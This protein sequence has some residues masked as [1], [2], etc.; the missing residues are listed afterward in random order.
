MHVR[1]DYRGGTNFLY[2]LG[3]KPDE[4]VLILTDAY[5]DVVPVNI[6]KEIFSARCKNVEIA[7]LPVD[8][9]PEF[10]VAIQRK[11]IDFDVVIITASQSWYH[12]PTRKRAKYEMKKRIVECYGLTIDL[13]K[14][15][16][17]CADPASMFDNAQKMIPL[18]KPGKIITIE[19][20]IGTVFSAKI[21]GVYI[22]TGDYREKGSGGNLPAGE[23]SFGLVEETANGTVVFDVSMDIL[24][25][26]QKRPL[27][28]EIRDGKVTDCSGELSQNF[29][30]L[31]KN[32]PRLKNIAE[33][34]IGIND[35]AILG[36][37]VIEDEKKIGTAHIGFG[38]DT[39]FGGNVTGPHYD[40][41]LSNV[42]VTVG[43]K[44]IICRGQLTV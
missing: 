28:V 11:I 15:G 37:H 2:R 7:Y 16:A 40:A 8:F 1:D 12:G 22:E 33:I 30:E 26:L 19:T 42:T 34:G 32:E 27:S 5:T 44:Q 4:Q 41:V 13:L 18:L 36:R 10:P 24:G 14:E 29:V 23:I 25:S 38:N 6:L 9:M 39:Y 20:A 43:R 3:L 31:I 21:D 35:L 17:L